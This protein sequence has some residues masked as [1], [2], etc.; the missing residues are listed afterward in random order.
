MRKKKWEKFRT[1]AADKTNRRHRNIE[2]YDFT[3]LR[4][5]NFTN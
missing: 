2:F 3:I 1:F 5:Y 4:F